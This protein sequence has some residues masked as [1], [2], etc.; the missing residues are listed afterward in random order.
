MVHTSD[1][2]SL[3]RFMFPM[4]NMFPNKNYKNSEITGPYRTVPHQ[5]VNLNIFRFAN[6]SINNTLPIILV[7]CFQFFFE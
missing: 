5:V 4:E 2:T 7:K 3:E 1:E 6:K